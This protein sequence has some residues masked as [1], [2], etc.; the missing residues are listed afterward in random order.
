MEF[1]HPCLFV[2]RTELSKD[3]AQIRNRAKFQ[4]VP[5]LE[6]SNSMDS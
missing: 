5:S 3:Q 1:I 4:S 6:R 2:P